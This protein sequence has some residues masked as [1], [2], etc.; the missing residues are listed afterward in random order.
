MRDLSVGGQLGSEAVRREEF[1]AVVILD[2]FTYG[3]QRHGV[4]VH[5]VRTHVVQGRGLGR[6]TWSRDD[7][8]DRTT[9]DGNEAR[10]RIAA[11]TQAAIPAHATQS[12]LQ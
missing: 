3:L 9:G 4:R 7:W 6:V 8:G 10:S 11:T 2:D 12:A 5:L 1:V